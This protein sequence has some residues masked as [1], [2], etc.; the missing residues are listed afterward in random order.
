MQE[1]LVRNHPK[2]NA[3]LADIEIS[4]IL[5]EE[6]KAQRNIFEPPAASDINNIFS[7]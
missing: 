7:L 5:I 2:V 4:A 3:Y 1:D 6:A